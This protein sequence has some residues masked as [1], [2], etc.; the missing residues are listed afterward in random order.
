MKTKKVKST[1]LA[2][3]IRKNFFIKTAA[4]NNKINSSN[5]EYNEYINNYKGTTRWQ[6]V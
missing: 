6:T 5:P 2:S 4:N 3:I 1:F